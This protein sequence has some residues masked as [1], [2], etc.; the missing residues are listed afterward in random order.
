MKNNGEQ[1]KICRLDVEYHA[2][3]FEFEF[4]LR[5]LLS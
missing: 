2:V 5:Q 4:R 3:G 1:Y